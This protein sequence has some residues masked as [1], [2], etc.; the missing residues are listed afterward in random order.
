LII[1]PFDFPKEV[2]FEIPEPGDRNIPSRKL[3]MWDRG[4]VQIA[5]ANLERYLSGL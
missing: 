2:L 5:H 3:Y 1:A 4:Q